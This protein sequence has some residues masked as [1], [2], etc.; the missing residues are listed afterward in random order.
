MSP[1]FENIDPDQ[2]ATYKQSWA[3]AYHFAEVLNKSPEL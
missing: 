2:S 3:V 1:T